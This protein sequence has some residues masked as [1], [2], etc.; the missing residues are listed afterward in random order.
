MELF[1]VIL[2][3]LLLLM[4]GW[5]VAKKIIRFLIFLALVGVAIYFFM[6]YL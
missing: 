2:I 3:G 6:N 5:K 1:A 4:V